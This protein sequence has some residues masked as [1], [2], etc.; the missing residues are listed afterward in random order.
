MC[1]YRSLTICPWGAGGA[2][3]MS[4]LSG[5]QIHCPVEQHP[6]EITVVEYVSSIGGLSFVVLSL[7]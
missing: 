6:D 5:D 2:Y 1:D 4:H 7:L 3:A